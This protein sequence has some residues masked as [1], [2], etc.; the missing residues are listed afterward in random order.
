MESI[1]VAPEKLMSRFRSWR[2][3]YKEFVYDCIFILP[4]FA[5]VSFLL[6]LYENCSLHYLRKF[7][8]GEK[9]YE[10]FAIIFALRDQTFY[11]Y[12]NLKCQSMLNCQSAIFGIIFFNACC[13]FNI[14][15]LPQVRGYIN[16]KNLTSLFT[17]QKYTPLP[18]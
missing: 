5:L 1:Y 4:H 7:L 11:S 18:L 9:H 2:D 15:P 16:P 8:N 13:S 10:Y 6:P 12:K 17:L 3:I 14:F